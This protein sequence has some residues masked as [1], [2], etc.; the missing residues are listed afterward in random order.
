MNKEGFPTKP[1]I[2]S[3]PCQG[4][5]TLH[6]TQLNL[7]QHNIEHQKKR[8]FDFL[9]QLG[10]KIKEPVRW[11]QKYQKLNWC[12]RSAPISVPVYSSKD[13]IP[14]DQSASMIPEHG[15]VY[16]HLYD[17]KLV[18][19]FWWDVLRSL[20]VYKRRGS[21]S[22]Y[23]SASLDQ[24]NPSLIFDFIDNLITVATAGRFNPQ[25]IISMRGSC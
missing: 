14:W 25:G 12:H 7:F 15:N 2:F 17:C 3:K 9:V 22:F 18:L 1:K 23:S 4:T 5:P 6:K 16:V 24:L 13:R 19:Q 11:R 20:N 10:K 21:W 8:M